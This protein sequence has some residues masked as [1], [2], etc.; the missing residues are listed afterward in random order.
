MWVLK[1][2]DGRQSVQNNAEYKEVQV[3][4]TQ[5][6]AFTQISEWEQ[7]AGKL[8]SVIPAELGGSGACWPGV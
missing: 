1:S 2:K 8:A 7:I 6:M 5:N 4:F 3:N